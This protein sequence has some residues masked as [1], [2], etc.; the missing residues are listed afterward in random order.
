MKRKENLEWWKE[1]KLGLFIHWGLYSLCGAGEWVMYVRRIPAGEY[2]KL[3]AQFN[4]TEFD[5]D[6]IVA[7]AKKAGM[8]Y[9]VITAKHHDGFSMF[10]TKVSDY[11]IV[12]ATPFGRDP[13]EELARACRREGL[14]L[15]FYYSHV[16]EW[17]HP[18]AQSFEKKG[19]GDLYGNYGNFWDYPNENRK[20][21]QTYIDQFDMPQIRELLEQYGDILTI[22]FDTPSQITPLQGE[23]LRKLVYETQEGCLV[24][25]RLSEEIETDYMTMADDAIPASGMEIPWETPMTTH[26]GWGYVENGVYVT[27]RSVVLKIAEVTA[28]GGNLLLNVGPDALGRI[29]AQSTE[30][31][32]KVGRW[33][34]KNG[35]AV[36]GTKAAGLPY[37]PGWGQVTR[38]ENAL[39]LML[40]GNPQGSLAL[41][42]LE[43]PVESCQVLESGE[44]LAFSQAGDRLEIRL[45]EAQG[46]SL[47]AEQDPEEVGIAVIK[48]N[49]PEGVRIKGGLYPGESGSV[50][51]AAAAGQVHREDPYSHMEVKNGITELW[52]SGKDFLTWEF[53]TKEDAAYRLQLVWDAKGF[54]GIEDLGHQFEVLVDDGAY[55]C[56]VSDRFPEEHGIRH[57]TV[58]EPRLS[59]GIHR[60][61]LIPKKI[62]MKQLMGLR[63]RGLVFEKL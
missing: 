36:Y 2:H 44:E 21:L 23:Q 15:G 32:L 29:P 8:R 24:N 34:E 1:A 56:E 25:S 61:K 47:A 58:D 18:M 35:E 19:R 40:T 42:G 49:C 12:D 13:M 6:A 45:S 33:L 14:K 51:L 55:G 46:S 16:R 62:V 5:A 26:N 54:W 20:D 4:P 3:A 39:Y 63:V 41:T 48:V 59:A 9:I 11:N 43:S 10:R 38:K 52:F 60:V 57:I 22:W 28:K 50:E 53:E 27:A 37:T 17:N 7:F 30:I 31:F